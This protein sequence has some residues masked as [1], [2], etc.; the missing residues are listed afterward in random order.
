MIFYDLETTGLDYSK[1]EIIEG[2][3]FD[4]ETG[5]ECHIRIKPSNPDAANQWVKDNVFSKINWDEYTDERVEAL[6]RFNQFLSQ[7]NNVHYGHFDHAMLSCELYR[8]GIRPAFYHHSI[9]LASTISMLYEIEK[10]SLKPVCEQLGIE[11]V[12]HHSAK[13]DVEALY[14]L[15][16]MVVADLQELHDWCWAC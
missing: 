11:L 1:C 8:L 14:K 3:A 7:T 10:P 4:D 16:R 15:Y 5:E 12:N 13:D 2:Y 6:S 9:D